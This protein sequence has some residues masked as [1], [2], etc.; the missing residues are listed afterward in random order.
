[1]I[2][3]NSLVLGLAVAG[4]IKRI[5]AAAAGAGYDLGA[6]EQKLWQAAPA[7]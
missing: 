4:Q 5:L 1:M 2:A 6:L 7:K 3:P